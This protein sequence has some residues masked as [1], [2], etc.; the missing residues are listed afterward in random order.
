MSG[1][2]RLVTVLGAAGIAA[3]VSSQ[4]WAPTLLRRSPAFEIRRVEISGMHLV[5]PHELLTTSGVRL[6]QNLWDDPGPWLAAL[7]AHPGIA[8]AVIERVPPGTLRIRVEERQ[9]IA[10]V[11]L[12]VLRAATL[13][14]ELLPVDPSRT[15]LDLPIVRGPV[16]PDG[17][18]GDRVEEERRREL[19]EALGAVAAL[20]RN[21]FA[22]VSE[23][24]RD[25]AG[26]VVLE[27][28]DPAVRVLV[29]AG[30]AP[31]RLHQ[32]LAVLE[33]LEGRHSG[34]RPGAS[35]PIDVD[36]RYADQ[37]VVRIPS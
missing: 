6:G 1:R 14:G 37:V 24:R 29:P 36:L 28:V 10:L 17:A 34:A 25:P 4:L 22:R 3:A 13:T 21:L 31:S 15:T 33:D 2:R 26:H 16:A 23:V 30:A 12:D 7:R 19:L 18:V 9:P 35:D 20:D 32:L 5:A 11:E 8:A 27:L